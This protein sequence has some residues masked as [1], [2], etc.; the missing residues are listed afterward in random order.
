MESS[1]VGLWGVDDEEERDWDMA[2]TPD[3]VDGMALAS[4]DEVLRAGPLSFEGE[5]GGVG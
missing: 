1:W 5:G 4:I 2:S 3:V